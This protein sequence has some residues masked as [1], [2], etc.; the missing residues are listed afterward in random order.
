MS[1][2]PSSSLTGNSNYGQQGDAAKSSVDVNVNTGAKDNQQLN[3]EQQQLQQNISSTST[4][5]GDVVHDRLSRLSISSSS[6]A[7]EDEAIGDRMIHVT[8]N[9]DKTLFLILTSTTLHLWY[10]KPSVEI[11]SHCRTEHSLNSLGFNESA[12]WKPDSAMIVVKTT[13][14]VLI[15]YRVAFKNDIELV[16][17]QQDP[18]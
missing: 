11:A 13:M 14:D 4:I 10:A 12:H 15:F 16:Y 3:Q 8:S 18:R 2:C 9:S 6:S 7:L 17:E 1:N 5:N